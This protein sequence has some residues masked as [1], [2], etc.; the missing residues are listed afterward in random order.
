M[1]N[2]SGC[3]FCTGLQAG[4]AETVARMRFRIWLPKSDRTK[5]LKK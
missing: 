3:Q 1:S 4:I 5:V 2:A